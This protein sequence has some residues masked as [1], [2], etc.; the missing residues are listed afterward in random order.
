M[1][2]SDLFDIANYA[3]NSMAF[4]IDLITGG[5]LWSVLG[6]FGFPS[7]FIFVLQ[8]VIG[9]LLVLTIFYFLSGR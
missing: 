8:G 9:F 3:W 1:C 4:I 7:E 5:F 2:S 6:V